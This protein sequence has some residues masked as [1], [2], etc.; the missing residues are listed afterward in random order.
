MLTKQCSRCHKLIP[1]GMRYCSTCQPIAEKQTEESKARSNRYYDADIRDKRSTRFYN[2]KPWKLLSQTI[3]QR[4]EYRCKECGEIA[5]EVHHKIPI[6]QDWT[7]R[8]DINNLMPVCA[9]CHK[10][11]EKR[12]K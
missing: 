9:S 11:I 8:F 5:T 1:Y 7:K 12:I 2:S 4:D 3:L 10:K 6:K